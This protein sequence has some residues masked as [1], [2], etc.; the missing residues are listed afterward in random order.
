LK[1]TNWKD[2]AELIGI[3]AIVASLVFVGLQMRQEQTIA[4]TET[5]S[6]VTQKIGEISAIIESSPGVWIRGLDGEELSAEERV[7]FYSMVEVV[8][9][10]FFDMFLRFRNLE[11][12]SVE[13]L[14]RDFA[15]AVYT[16]PGLKQAYISEFESD[17]TRN[18][19]YGDD[20]SRVDDFRNLVMQYLEELEER[21]PPVP[22]EKRYVFW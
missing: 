4:I 14:A 16:Y 19:A 7:V 17:Q 12:G 18:Q 1:S 22:A 6:T 11:I 13:P 2:I 10:F 8:E 15:F 21:G 5:R 20:E 9:S 3:A